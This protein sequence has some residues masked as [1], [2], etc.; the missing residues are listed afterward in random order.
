[1]SQFD[2]L[3]KSLPLLPHQGRSV[4]AI[5]S[6]YLFRMLGLFMVLPVL[7]LYGRDYQHSSPFLLGLALGAYGCSQAILQIPFGWWSDRW[8]RRPVIAIGLTIFAL[9]SV[10]AATSESVYGLIIGRFLQGSGAI[11]SALMAM[12]A[13][14]TSERHRSKAM[15]AIGISIGVSFSLALILGPLLTRW[16]GL[17]G[18]FWLTAALAILGLAILYLFIPNLDGVPRAVSGEKQWLKAVLLEKELLRLDWGILVLHL[19]LMANFVAVP[20]L[21]ESVAN[22][23][24]DHHWWVYLPTLLGAFVLML[25]LMLLGERRGHLKVVF[26]GAIATLLIVEIL[27]VLAAATPWV[28]LACLFVFF[29]GFN[30]LEASLPSQVSK[31]APASLRGTASGVYSSSQFMGAF[32]GGVLGGGVLTVGGVSAVFAMNAVAL[33]TWLIVA[34]PMS[35]QSSASKMQF[36]HGKGSGSQNI[37]DKELETV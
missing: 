15:A 17:S 18:V 27:L 24:R 12:V 28:L 36:S 5:A 2:T 11:A 8:G 33:T 4:A 32:L 3:A 7:T 37:N 21:L 1:M 23:D 30:L 10:V 25:P 22:I 14:A 20:G 29:V 19:V 31:M 26:L 6:L 35:V 16:G 13:D 9:G 34:W